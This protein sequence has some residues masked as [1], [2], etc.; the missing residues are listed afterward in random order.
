MKRAGLYDSL[1]TRYNAVSCSITSGLWLQVLSVETIRTQTKPQGNDSGMSPEPPQNTKQ[2][3]VISTARLS[4]A[5]TCHKYR[6][7]S[8][9][10]AFC[11]ALK[12]DAVF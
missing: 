4:H 12:G 6:R 2:Q 11:H 7:F 5:V 3:L 8:N 10:T 9:L 1:L